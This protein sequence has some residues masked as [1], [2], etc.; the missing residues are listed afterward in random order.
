MTVSL[1]MVPD[2]E[3]QKR[4]YQALGGGLVRWQ[5]I[6]TG[7]YL[8]ALPLMGTDPK[9]CSLTFFQIKA[10]ENK[11]AF[12]DRLIFHKLDQ[13]T[14][15]KAWAP[16][17][18]EIRKAIEFRNSLAHFEMFI[19]TDSELEKASPK[20]A[21]RAVLSP[22]HLDHRA[23]RGGTT[24]I[25]SVETMEHN[26]NELRKLSYRLMYFVVDHIPQTETLTASLEPNLRQWL[27][28]FRKRPRPQGFEPPLRSSRPKDAPQ[29]TES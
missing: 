23:K 9:T 12:V 27:D 11:L 8:I 3:D 16:I 5:F 20:T 17:L 24:K 25:L 10:A 28:S 18:E 29:K 7:L 13:R 1:P 2:S 26:A 14:R 19:L 21:F 4:M 6:E 15:K 22:H